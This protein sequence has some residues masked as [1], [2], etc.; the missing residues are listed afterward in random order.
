M[1][2]TIATIIIFGLLLG[3]VFYANNI[4]LNL[5]DDIILYTE[6]IYE[7]IELGDWQE[8]QNKS[9]D[10]IELIEDEEVI[11]SV[12]VNHNDYDHITD[13]AIQL[14]IYTKEENHMESII[15]V[16]SLKNSATNIKQ[17]HQT[18]IENIF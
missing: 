17:L 13:E 1:K 3:F 6:E 18:T 10:L 5:C 2:N 15:S 16:K 7:L 14:S 4:L 12:Y 8:A 9:L 11:V